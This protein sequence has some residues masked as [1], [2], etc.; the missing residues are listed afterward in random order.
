MERTATFPGL[1]A[2]DRATASKF[3]APVLV[4][5][6]L[7]H[8]TFRVA[9]TDAYSRACAITHEHSLPAPEAAHI[10]PYA[11]EGTHSVS[12]GLLL[13][14]DIHRLFDKGY[15]TVTPELRFEVS[16]RL[17]EDF[18]NGRS[19]FPLRGQAIGVPAREADRPDAGALRWHN[20]SVFLG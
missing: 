13:R 18:S 20:E 9:V 15:V 2:E 16:D 8:G 17:R 11:R 7:G 3:G 12:N 19:Y 6:R 4:A 14:S 5:P 1:V 10:R